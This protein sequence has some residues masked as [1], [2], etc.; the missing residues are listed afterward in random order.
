MTSVFVDT[1]FYVAF[2]NRHDTG[3]EFAIQ[4]SKEDR[5]HVTTECVLWELGNAMS[6]G[7]D[8]TLFISFV[9]ALRDDPATRIIPAD[10]K[11]LERSLELFDQRPD[12]HGP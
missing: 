4:R 1:S 9:A 5:T 6:R 10:S 7:K 8:R 2:L 11:L 12:K 3:H